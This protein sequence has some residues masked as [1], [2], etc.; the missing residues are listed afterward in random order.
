MSSAISE[1]PVLVAWNQHASTFLAKIDEFEHTETSRLIKG[2]LD[3]FRAQLEDPTSN[4]TPNFAQLTIDCKAI[5][6]NNLPTFQ[7]PKAENL[8]TTFFQLVLGATV[9]LLFIGL[10]LMLLAKVAALCGLATIASFHF[11]ELAIKAATCGSILGT[12]ATIG[13]FSPPTVA[14]G[15]LDNFIRSVQPPSE[16]ASNRF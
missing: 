4:G 5:F 12:V 10:M 14:G 1:N 6:S 16:T 15:E 7:M 9:T 2:K 11:K 3:I 8:I 13:M